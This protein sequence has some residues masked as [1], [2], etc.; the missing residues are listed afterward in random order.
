M[1]EKKIVY[2][3]MDGVIAQFPRSLEEVHPSIRQECKE[4]CDKTGEHYSDFEGL[5]ATLEPVEGTHKAISKLIGHG[6]TVFI[7]STGPWANTSSGSDKRRWL[8]KHFSSIPSPS[9]DPPVFPKKHLMLTHRKDLNRGAYLV[10]DRVKNGA[11]EFGEREGQEWIHFGSD[12]FPDWE[13]VLGYL[14]KQEI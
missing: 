10:D 2:V 6:Y 1:D 11:K 3:D 7:L 8:E 4:W 12:K 13:S 5:F 14:L 9:G